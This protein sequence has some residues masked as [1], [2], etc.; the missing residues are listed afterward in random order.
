M[1][2]KYIDAAKGFAMLLIVWGHTVSF[3]DP[4][5]TWALGFKI[6]LF[7][8]VTG[9]LLSIR[10][11]EDCFV[12]KTPIKKLTASMGVPYAF[13]SLLSFAA[14]AVMFFVQKES[15]DFLAEKLLRIFTLGGISTL[16]FLPSIFIGRALFERVYSK[17]QSGTTRLLR[18]GVELVF[19]VAASSLYGDVEFKTEVSLYYAASMILL[20]IL[21]GL[22]AFWFIAVGYEIGKL[23]AKLNPCVAVRWISSLALVAVSVVFAVFNKDVDFNNGSLG[24]QPWKFFVTGIC[25][26]FGV[27]EILSLIYSRF[28]LRFLEYVGENSLFVMATHLPLYIVPVF[29][30]VAEKLLS[31][32]GG[33]MDYFRA[34]AV[35]AATL[36]AEWIFI[37]V[38]NKATE[39][40]KNKKIAAF[41]RR[42]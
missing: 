42:I 16:W 34:I 20:V 36:V 35:F 14:A 7:Y 17:K 6:T 13:Y 33:A 19:V 29:S 8:I 26:S 25:G 12:K 28:S 27:I 5:A 21:K 39:K 40:V 9:F 32:E 4:V 3:A 41:L 24:A 18:L 31:A 2:L 10:S 11:G 1:R 37:T 38:K 30:L 23:R 22:I 15:T